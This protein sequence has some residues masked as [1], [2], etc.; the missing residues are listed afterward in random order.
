MKKITFFICS[1]SSGGAEHQLSM[2]A[3]FLQEKN[4]DI[5]IITFTDKTDHYHLNDG[6]KRVRITNKGNRILAYMSIFRIIVKLKTD[7]FISF[8]QRENLLSLVPFLFRKDVNY[9]A[10]ERNFTIGK[11]SMCEKLLINFLYKRADYIVPNSYSQRKHIIECNKRYESKTITITNYTD[12]N[13]YKFSETPTNEII[14]IGIFCRFEAQKNCHRFVEAI[15]ELKKKTNILFV[16]EWYGNRQFSNL[17]SQEYYDV[18]Y[19]K[20]IE[21]GLQDHIILHDSV[22]NVAELMSSFDAICLPSLHEGFSNTISEGICCG[23]PM[24]VSNVSDNHLMVRDGENGFLFN[25]NSISDIVDAF[26]KFFRLNEDG[27]KEFA[28]KSRIIAEELFNKEV[29]IKSYVSLIEGQ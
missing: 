21:L 27:R 22:K 6:I 11:Q 16:I 26:E 1:L 15:Y 23:K 8:G 7:C 10:G 20:I 5:T 19:R 9:I 13:E 28:K 24:L 4:Y 3:N 29:F 2:L 18:L 25:P 14:K 12:L 17:T